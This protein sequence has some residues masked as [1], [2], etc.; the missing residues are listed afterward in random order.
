MKQ[1]AQQHIQQKLID[2]VKELLTNTELNV[3][4]IVYHLGFEHPQSLHK[5]FKNKRK[6]SPLEYRTNFK[7]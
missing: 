4:Q 7:K 1:S 5:V 3:S 2:C 6:L